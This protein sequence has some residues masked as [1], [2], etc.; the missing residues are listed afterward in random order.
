MGYIENKLEETKKAN[1]STFITSLNLKRK[2]N[3]IYIYYDKTTLNINTLKSVSKKVFDN[4]FELKFSEIEKTLNYINS[5]TSENGYPFSKLYLSNISIQDESNLKANLIIEVPKQKR[6][7]NNIIIKGYE[8]FPKSYLK[9]YLKIKPSQ[10][11]DLNTIKS[12]TEQLNN[13]T[14]TNEIKS[15]EVLFSKDS[16][17]L[18]LYLEKTKSN[19]F[20]G[21]LG[22]G[23]NE[24]T[25][26]LEF[27][28]YLSLNLTNNL[29]YGESFSLLYKSDENDQK[30]FQADIT[31]PYLFNSPVGADFLLRIFKKDSSFTTINQSA[32][33]H[34]Q[35][36]S[37]HK[38]YG[39]IISTE[40]NNLLT[41]N[42]TST[43]T[44]YKTQ[45]YT[46][47]YQFL[48]PQSYNL[49]FP[50]KSKVYL[51]ANFGK[52]KTSIN[53]EKQ[54]QLT[55]DVFKIFNLNQKNSFYFRL[56]GSNLIS[57][58]YFENELLR[59]GGINSIRGFEENS[60][61]ST[62][63]GV[64]NSEYRLQLNNS[65]YIHSITDIAYFENKTNNI[66]EKLFGYGF[67]F[68][69]LT[70]AGLFK[71]NYANGKTE[72]TKFKLSNSKI[73][74]SLIATF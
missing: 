14:F 34:Y 25:S 17:T 39:G 67:G 37:R 71:F 45:Y 35:I 11:F 54:S 73:H 57:D 1:D 40:S 9:H 48:N 16:T 58:T 5:K 10:V 33:L 50:I 3:T 56:N 64:I 66:K 36:N 30:T 43:I 49:L 55:I 63:N 44:D 68:G 72:N 41:E 26:K 47:A 70:K 69:I 29:N 13:L 19:S 23:T 53:S 8:K 51:E 18:Y 7:I 2:F 59:F 12:K 31:S 21:F 20:D 61:F 24:K 46:F 6:S 52:R 27:D 42:I 22:F 60:L 65:I 74:L 4:Y 32:K 28:G 38:I 62:L 15:P